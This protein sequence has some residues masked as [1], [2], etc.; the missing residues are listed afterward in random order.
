MSSD[1]F[2]CSRLNFELLLLNKI[3]SPGFKAASEIHYDLS[4]ENKSAF[5]ATF[6][7]LI[8]RNGS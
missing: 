6:F 4:Q 7:D 3:I 2:L 8:I 5:D 1:N